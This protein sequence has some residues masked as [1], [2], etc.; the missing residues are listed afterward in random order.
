MILLLLCFYSKVKPINYSYIYQCSMIA[1]G[2]SNV[3][4]VVCL[5][6]KREE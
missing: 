4:I 5:Q 1:I 3:G 2:I 6:P